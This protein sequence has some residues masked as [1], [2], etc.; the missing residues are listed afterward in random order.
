MK[1][2]LLDKFNNSQYTQLNFNLPLTSLQSTSITPNTF[3]TKSHAKFSGAGSGPESMPTC[4]TVSRDIKLCL[5][6]ICIGRFGN[7]YVGCW[8]EKKVFVK[9]FLP[10]CEKYWSNEWH[11]LEMT[12]G[13]ENIVRLITADKFFKSDFLEQWLVTE[14]HENGSL[15]Y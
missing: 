12:Q 11:I 15:Y 1:K 13:N 5:P 3:D 6:P 4:R 14:Y 8:R 9:R 7:E 2:N 10:G